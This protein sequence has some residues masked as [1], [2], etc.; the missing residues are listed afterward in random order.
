MTYKER[1][2]H[3]IAEMENRTEYNDGLTIPELCKRML[4][5]EMQV[6][7][8][9][10]IQ[11][12]MN[13]IRKK[14]DEPN[15]NGDYYLNAKP[16]DMSSVGGEDYWDKEHEDLNKVKQIKK[17]ICRTRMKYR[18]GTQYNDTTTHKH[19]Y[20]LLPPR[21]Q[22]QDRLWQC[23]HIIP[24][25]NAHLMEP[26]NMRNEQVLAGLEKQIKKLKALENLTDEE[27]KDLQ[28]QERDRILKEF[29]FKRISSD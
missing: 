17:M 24:E 6:L 29:E 2:I 21:L 3:L 9:K 14:W 18:S 11:K 19:Q 8:N 15:E 16:T 10:D 27:F 12:A 1:E 20:Y 7:Y 22:Q 23:V 13:K 4:G 5:Y 25:E 28:K 26:L